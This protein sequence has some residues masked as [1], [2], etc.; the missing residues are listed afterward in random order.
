MLE[1]EPAQPNSRQGF[2]T[3]TS[4]RLELHDEPQFEGH[5]FLP[6][7]TLT[8]RRLLGAQLGYPPLVSGDSE[9]VNLSFNVCKIDEAWQMPEYFEKYA[10]FCAVMLGAVTEQPPTPGVKTFS[11]S[12][13]NLPPD[14]RNSQTQ[15]Q[16]W[17]KDFP[18]SKHGWQ[19][20]V[21]SRN[22]T[23]VLLHE[24][25][26]DSMSVEDADESKLWRPNPGEVVILGRYTGHRR[27]RIRKSST[28]RKLVSMMPNTTRRG[29]LRKPGT[30]LLNR[31]DFDECED[32]PVRELPDVVAAA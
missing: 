12:I 24:T 30:R 15:G 28:N 6:G 23:Q 25:T 27:G 16:G 20:L 5:V 14:Y 22:T 19:A 18:D 29:Y 11:F 32:V 7:F 3:I 31:V 10:G 17:H 2:P 8:D 26:G 13:E 4:G 1:L 9:V 21:T